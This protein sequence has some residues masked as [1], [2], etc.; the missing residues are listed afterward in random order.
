MIGVLAGGLA[1]LVTGVVLGADK[2]AQCEEETGPDNPWCGIATPGYGILGLM[3][4]AAIGAVVGNALIK[5]DR[6]QQVPLDQL[7]VSLAPQRDG[8]LGI[9]L[10]VA[11]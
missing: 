8:R 4:G 1:G 7:R 3:G 6:W 11:F 2:T 9:G 5:I 10:S